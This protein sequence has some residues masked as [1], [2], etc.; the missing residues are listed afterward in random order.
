MKPCH[1]A[2]DRPDIRGRERI[3]RLHAKRLVLA[4]DVD[5]AAVAGKTPGMAGADLANIVNEREALAKIVREARRSRST[6]A[7]VA[8]A[9]M[10]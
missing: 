3:L 6:S 9:A 1:V 7:T 4:A 10:T 5:L 2:I 8:T